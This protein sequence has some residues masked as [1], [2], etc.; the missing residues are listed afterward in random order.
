MGD[1]LNE[2]NVAKT[3]AAP[4]PRNPRFALDEVC[5]IA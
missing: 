1:C 3:M 4:Y 2:G 5:S